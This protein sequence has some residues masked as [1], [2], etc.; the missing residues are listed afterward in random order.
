M[1]KGWPH[2]HGREEVVH[3]AGD[4]ARGRVARGGVSPKIMIERELLRAHEEFFCL[5]GRATVCSLREQLVTRRTSR[6][7]AQ[8]GHRE[9]SLASETNHP[10]LHRRI[11][12]YRA[13]SGVVGRGPSRRRA[14][15][16][17]FF[18]RLGPRQLVVVVDIPATRSV[19]RMASD[20]PPSGESLLSRD[21]DLP[22]WA[23][24][25]DTVRRRLQAEAADRAA[26]LQ[27]E[28]AETTRSIR[29]ARDKVDAALAEASSLAGLGAQSADTLE[30]PRQR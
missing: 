17:S 10:L 4:G 15:P 9:S 23:K 24:E 30:S 28:S 19:V 18:S 21:D 7:G 6:G 8:L 16:A 22:A 14:S 11:S 12:P 26:E 2:L 1:S 27:R 3:V 25:A 29:V 20:A 5:L 13:A